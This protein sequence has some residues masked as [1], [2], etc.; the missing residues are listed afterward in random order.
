MGTV[1]VPDRYRVPKEGEIVE[2]RYL[3]CYPGEE[4]K[5]I[6]AKYFGKIRDDIARG[7]CSVSQ[8]KLKADESD[9]TEF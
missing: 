4:G 7:D 8:L 5:L 3:Y 6:Q 9:P 1:G 2:V